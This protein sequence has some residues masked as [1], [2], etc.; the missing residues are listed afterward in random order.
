[1]K[2]VPVPQG[3]S[4]ASLTVAETAW[5]LGVSAPIVRRLIKDGQL[6]KVPHLG[7][8]VRVPAQAVEN[9]AN[10]KVS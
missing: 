5:A 9:F 8:A 7:T 6:P 10:G 3:V 1:M 4:K 2:D